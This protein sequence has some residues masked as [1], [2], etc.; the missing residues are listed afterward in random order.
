MDPGPLHRQK[1]RI[2]E[3][4]E[5]GHESKALTKS[6]VDGFLCNRFSSVKTFQ[7]FQE[8]QIFGRRGE[9]GRKKNKE[10]PHRAKMPKMVD[11]FPH[12]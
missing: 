11:T 1:T 8:L 2:R 6:V 10:V 7:V 5:P 12:S 9:V 4:Q 3:G